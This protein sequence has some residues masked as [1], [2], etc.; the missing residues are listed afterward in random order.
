[1]TTVWYEKWEAG[2][3][4]TEDEAKGFVHWYESEM[5]D[6]LVNEEMSETDLLNTYRDSQW[7]VDSFLDW[8]W[9][10]EAESRTQK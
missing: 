10:Q 9:K 3:L 5:S 6:G 8:A 1:M 7:W 2:Y 4:G